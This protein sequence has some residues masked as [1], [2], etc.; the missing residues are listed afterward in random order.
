M[1]TPEWRVTDHVADNSIQTVPFLAIHV[2]V[3]W[4]PAYQ[5][6]Q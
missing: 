3:P 1:N 6:Q 5:D 2:W 4:L